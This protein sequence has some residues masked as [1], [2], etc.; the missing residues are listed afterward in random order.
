MA[1]LSSDHIHALR[2]LA[3]KQAG[4][5]VDYISISAAR[6]LTDMGYA[7]RTASGWIISQ[8]GNATL[9]TTD[10]ALRETPSAKG[11]TPFR[12]A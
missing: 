2:N 10:K 11:V 8:L 4:E 9:S 7:E 12:R 5:D 1:E 6:A 3:R